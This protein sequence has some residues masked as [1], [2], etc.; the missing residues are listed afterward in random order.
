MT[1]KQVSYHLGDNLNI[2][3]HKVPPLT[4]I[5][6]WFVVLH[7]VILHF[8]PKRTNLRS[9]LNLVTS[10]GTWRQWTKPGGGGGAKM[11]VRV[12]SLPIMWRPYRLVDTYTHTH[13]HSGT[14][15]PFVYV[16]VF[17]LNLPLFVK[18]IRKS[19]SFLLRVL[20]RVLIFFSFCFFFWK[21]LNILTS[22]QKLPSLTFLDKIDLFLD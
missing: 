18:S 2:C 14:P 12:C 17:P 4:V 10:S 21:K 13:P 11:A 6:L 3:A 5:T 1:I 7:H 15:S 22:M 20:V 16:H 9:R 8:L 19:V